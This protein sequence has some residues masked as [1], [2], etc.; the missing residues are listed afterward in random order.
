M[1]MQVH[2][3]WSKKL[4][5]DILHHQLSQHKQPAGDFSSSLTSFEEDLFSLALQQFL[6]IFHFF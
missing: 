6:S 2:N 5:T 4:L 3:T 1:D